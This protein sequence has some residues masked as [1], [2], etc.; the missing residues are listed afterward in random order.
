M[1]SVTIY[2]NNQWE[3]IMV[4]NILLFDIDG[5]L[6]SSA[7]A[8]KDALEKGMAAKFGV[9]HIVDGLSLS[10]RTDKGILHDLLRLHGIEHT[11]A[12]YET[13]MKAYLA[14]L[15][16]CLKSVQGKILP[17]IKTM[18][19]DLKTRDDCAVGLLT[20]N[21]RAGAKIKLGHFGIFEHFEFGGFGDHHLDRD[22]VAR[23]ALGEIHTRFGKDFST[24]KIWVLGDTPLDIKCARAIGAK[25]LAVAT[26]WHTMKE[27]ESH[28]PDLLFED[29]THTEDVLKKMLS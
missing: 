8:G 11:E 1:T 15:P 28:G 26:G 4:K 27:L 14:N 23:E 10:G 6:L 5:T 24:S 18:L 3:T 29:L 16:E 20:G 7:G 12:S 22:D 13:M 21:L 25:V 19:E 9:D 2:I 17:G